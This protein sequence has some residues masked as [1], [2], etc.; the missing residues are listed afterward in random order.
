MSDPLTSFTKSSGLSETDAITEHKTKEQFNGQARGTGR[1]PNPIY[2]A[3]YKLSGEAS[4]QN[5]K[6]AQNSKGPRKPYPT[7]NSA[8]QKQPKVSREFTPKGLKTTVKTQNFEG[9]KAQESK[10]NEKLADL[11]KKIDQAKTQ[12]NGDKPQSILKPVANRSF[13]R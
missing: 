8:A 5:D 7:K 12:D 2:D 1:G 9:F 13:R 11:F 4:N 6:P 10:K 3:G